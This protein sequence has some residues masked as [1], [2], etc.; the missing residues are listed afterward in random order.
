MLKQMKIVK[1]WLA[2]CSSIALVSCSTVPVPERPEIAICVADGEG[3]AMCHGPRK[4]PLKPKLE[5]ITGYV[6]FAP[7]DYMTDEA[8]IRQVL[9]VRRGF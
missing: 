9:E 1:N 8:W 6:C 7:E 5:R 4:E 3:G 2:A